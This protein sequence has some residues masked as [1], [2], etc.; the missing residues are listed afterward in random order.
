MN[1]AIK[2]MEFL[3]KVHKEK[4]LDWQAGNSGENLYNGAKKV[5]HVIDDVNIINYI[6]SYAE[7]LN[8]IKDLSFDIQDLNLS[9]KVT[10]RI[11]QT[12]SIQEKLKRYM[13][14]KHQYGEVQLKKCLNDILGFRIVLNEFDSH[15]DVI[16]ILSERFEKIKVVNAD[17]E[18]YVAVHAYFMTGDNK[19]FQWEL[20]IWN[21]K[22]EM[23]N[24]LSHHKYK[25]DYISWETDTEKEEQL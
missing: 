3:Y 17:K 8:N 1:D 22:D 15:E 5:C 12:N 2:L 19:N 21:K 24:L 7:F 14:D 16:N 23:T 9:S 25:Q 18:D 11:K 13:T 4:N 6:Y 10:S 20:Q